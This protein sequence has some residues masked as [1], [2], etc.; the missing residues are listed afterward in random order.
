MST[1]HPVILAIILISTLIILIMTFFTIQQ[2]R[3][4][5]VQRLGKF[6]RTAGPGLN[7]KIPFLETVV[8]EVDLR[9]QELDLTIE[10]KSD[11]S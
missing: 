10:T 8:G 7:I 11:Q 6:A 3:V 9:V 2:R 5:I 1:M 4:G